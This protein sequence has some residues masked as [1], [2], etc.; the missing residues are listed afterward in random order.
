MSIRWNEFNPAVVSSHTHNALNI[1]NELL[2][3]TATPGMTTGQFIRIL[4]NE[5][6]RSEQLWAKYMLEATAFIYARKLARRH[7]RMDVFA[8]L[9]VLMREAWGMF[10]EELNNLPDSRPASPTSIVMVEL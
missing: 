5:S 6:A 3:I 8:E 4:H 9:T 7:G 2:R 1:C 10:I